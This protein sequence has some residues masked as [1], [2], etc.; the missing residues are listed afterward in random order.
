VVDPQ[1]D[2]RSPLVLKLKHNGTGKE[3][4][5][6]VNHLYRGNGIDARRLDQATALNQWAAAQTL[7]VIAVGDYNFDYDL[8]PGQQAQNYDK[9]L[10]IC[11]PTGHSP[12]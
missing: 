7:P 12:G 6:M 10:G 9:G 8:D 4:F 1:Y 2:P 3:F 5:F 11:V